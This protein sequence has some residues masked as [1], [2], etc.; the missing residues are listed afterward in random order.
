[1]L[2]LLL[3]DPHQQKQTIE[4]R[5]AISELVN[6]AQTTSSKIFKP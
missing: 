2:L 4:K 5:Q 1:L 6:K 3:L